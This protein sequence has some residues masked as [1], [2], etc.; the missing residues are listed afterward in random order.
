MVDGSLTMLMMATVV[1]EVLVATIMV[2][3]L[4]VLRLVIIM[5]VKVFPSY[6]IA[7]KL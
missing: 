6:G 2:F 7:I 3:V 5:E 1:E 4:S